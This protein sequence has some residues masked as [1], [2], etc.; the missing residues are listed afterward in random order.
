V[1]VIQTYR[2][3]HRKALEIAERLVAASDAAEDAKATRRTLS[4]LAGA[5]RVHLAME[6]RSLYPAL[7][8]HTDAT[9][10]GTATRFQKEMGGLSDAL[11]DYSQRWTSTAIAGDWAGFRSETRAIVRALDER[12]RREERELYPL[13]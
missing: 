5:L 1:S 7:A 3:Q 2:E 4:E 6:D 9:I 11:Q 8:K 12:I 13:L 10:R